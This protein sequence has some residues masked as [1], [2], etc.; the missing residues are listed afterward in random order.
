M[1]VFNQIWQVWKRFG[2]FMGD[3]VARVVLTVFYFT[4]FLP[5]GLGTRFLSDPLMLRQTDL[6]SWLER[7]TSD[8]TIADARRLS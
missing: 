4:L 5:F 7:T 2:N 6:P 3:L 8:L 1:K